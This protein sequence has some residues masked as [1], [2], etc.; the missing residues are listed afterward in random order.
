MSRQGFDAFAPERGIALLE[1]AL[2]GGSAHRVPWALQL[3]RVAKSLGDSV[4]ALW[5]ALVRPT[6]RRGEQAL[7]LKDLLA[8]LSDKERRERVNSMVRDEIALVL[9]LR[10]ASDV[11]PTQ[12][13]D[14]LGLDSLMAVEL[15]NRLSDRFGTRLPATLLFDYPTVATLGRHLLEQVLHLVGG[16]AEPEDELIYRAVA[17]TP[18]A[19][20]QELGL[21]DGLRLLA[22]LRAIDGAVIKDSDQF[23]QE[24]KSLKDSE[25]TRLLD[26]EIDRLKG[27]T[28]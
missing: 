13:L 3:K 8:A 21:L 14:R 6:A 4:P 15:R 20:L 26:T 10:S 18:I 27:Q 28:S 1:L 9:G 2:R 7:G 5:R 24:I 25:L 17:Q 12:P 16:H 11:V 19:R 22:G 23:A